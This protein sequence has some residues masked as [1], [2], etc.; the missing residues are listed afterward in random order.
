MTRARLAALVA[1]VALAGAGTATGVALSRGGGHPRLSPLAAVSG[2]ATKAPVPPTA[3]SS[4]QPA[5]AGPSR[6]AETEPALAPPPPPDLS[7]TAPSGP[8]A[9]LL[10]RVPTAEPVVFVTIDDGWFRDPR[11]VDFIQQTHLP[12][13]VFLIERA[14]LADPDYFR[15]L[16]AAGATIEDHTYDHPRL[17][18]LGYERQR[19][20]ICRPV[21]DYPGL[22]GARPTLLRPPW[23]QFN[24]ATLEAARSCGLDTVVEWSAT[25]NDG[26]L[27]YSDGGLGPGDI[28]LMH[29]RPDLYGNLQALV[30]TVAAD[31]LTVASLESYLG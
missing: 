21:A 2:R 30:A 18:R 17:R 8:F 15:A 7:P 5:T 19:Q 14:A 3:G 23:G 26:V 27:R 1:A 13:S 4:A 16:Q 10:Y 11:V 29:F 22:L 6:T 31:G 24:R 9:R 12:V 28:V 25:M 20:E